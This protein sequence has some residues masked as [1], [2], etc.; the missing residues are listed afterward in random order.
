M[1]KQVN[2]RAGAPV[3]RSRFV[4]PLPRATL[5]LRTAEALPIHSSMHCGQS[6]PTV[7]GAWRLL[8]FTAK[9]LNQ[10]SPGARRPQD[11]R[12]QGPGVN[13]L[14]LASSRRSW[15]EEGLHHG[16]SLPASVCGG[17]SCPQAPLQLG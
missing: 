16:P 6:H 14:W 10:G 17:G 5:S 9:R 11:P 7:H 4:E 13:P 15:Q 1:V 2:H 12:E 3:L 8:E